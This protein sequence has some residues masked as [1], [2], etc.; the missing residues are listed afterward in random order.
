MRVC[1]DISAGLA[2]GAGVGRYA[3]ELALALAAVLGHDLVLFHNQQSRDRLPEELRLLGRWQVPLSNKMWRLQLLLPMRPMRIAADIFH[4]ADTLLPALS[5]PSIVTIH[6]LTARLY[7][8]HHTHLHRWYERFAVPI[9]TR[10]AHAVITD[11]A[12]TRQDLMRILPVPAEKIKV[13]HLGVDHTRFQPHPP[14]QARARIQAALGIDQPYF[15]AVGTREPRKNLAVLLH[16]YALLLGRLGTR[17]PQLVLTGA[18]G[19]G[20]DAA[21]S[22][23][24]SHELQ[25]RVLLPGYVSDDLLPDLYAGASAFVYP[26]LYEGFGLPILEAMACGV[27]VITSNTSSMPEVAEGAALLV[28]PSDVEAIA[29]AMHRI[30]EDDA[31]ALHLRNS[32]RQRAQRFTWQ[33]TAHETLQVYADVLESVKR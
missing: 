5:I 32:G 15:L 21:S 6:D 18:K 2:Q 23:A 27:P 12:S 11:S 20:H 10:R 24:Q 8:E 9:F 3:R 17:T 30:F 4:G 13:V 28:T 19:W 1:L 26:S 25:G 22:L 14:A 33:R 31:L 7:P 29:A 16:A